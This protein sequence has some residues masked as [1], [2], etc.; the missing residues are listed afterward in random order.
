M[1][2]PGVTL[3]AG[4]AMTWPLTL[5]RPAA[6]HASA[7]RREQS[8]ARAITLAMRSEPLGDGGGDANSGRGSEVLSF[9]PRSHGRGLR[10]PYGI[11]SLSRLSAM[12]EFVD[13][14]WPDSRLCWQ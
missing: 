4:E 11:L 5:T 14:D 9:F 3:R 10:P 1:R 8:P 12:A 6:I 2:S 7:S 13:K